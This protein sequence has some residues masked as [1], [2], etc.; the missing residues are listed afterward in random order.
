LL[1]PSGFYAVGQFYED[2]RQVED[3]EVIALLA[4]DA[5]ARSKP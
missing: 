4:R 5:S 2:F 1:A 3:E